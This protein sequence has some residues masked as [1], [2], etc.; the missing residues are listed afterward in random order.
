MC[1]H[2]QYSLVQHLK[3]TFFTPVDGIFI[4]HFF[5][6][7]TFHLSVPIKTDSYTPYFVLHFPPLLLYHPGC[8]LQCVCVSN[9]CI[10]WSE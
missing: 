9:M 6:C 8:Q 7:T 3:K 2:V 4:S 5:P 1:K 10:W